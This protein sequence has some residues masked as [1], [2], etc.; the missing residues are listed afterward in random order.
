M[1]FGIAVIFGGYCYL[2]G[3]II[4]YYIRDTWKYKKDCN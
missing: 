3:I 1:S 2:I 4:G